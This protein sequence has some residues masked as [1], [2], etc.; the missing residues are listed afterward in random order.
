MRV[1]RFAR[2]A[3]AYNNRGFAYADQR[4]FDKAISDYNEAIRLNPNLAIAYNNRGI[5]YRRVGDHN[6]AHSDFATA[7]R[8]R[9]GQ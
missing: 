9:A 5:A 1:S 7:K 6:K 3:A 4:K 2:Y 8:L